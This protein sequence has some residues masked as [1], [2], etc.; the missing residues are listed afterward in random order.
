MRGARNKRSE[1]S[2]S[3]SRRD[4]EAAAVRP[5]PALQQTTG[6]ESEA[7]P[8][9]DAAASS[10]SLHEFQHNA[11]NQALVGLLSAGVIQRK[12]KDSASA[13]PSSAAAAPATTP[14]NGAPAL[15]VEDDAQEMKSGQMRK[16][17]FLGQ[18]RTAVSGTAEEALAGTMWSALGCPYIDRWLG[19]YGNQPSSYLERA[20][21]KYAPE[22]AGVRSARE[23]IPLVTQ[24]VR[25]GIEEWRSTGEVKDLPPEFAQGGMPGMSVSGLVGAGLSAVG[26]AAAG[27]VKG[28][29]RAISGAVSGIGSALSSVGSMLFKRREGSDAEA[30]EDPE[31]IR[32]QL[33]GGQ[34][35]DSRVQG[36]MKSAFGVDFAGVRVHTDGR[37]KELADGLDARAFTIGNDIAFG[38]QEYQPGTP[39][40]DALIA[41]ELA[42]VV[43]QGS[44]ENSRP[45]QKGGHSDHLEEDADLSAVNA[46]VSTWTDTK[47]SLAALGGNAIPRLRSGLRLQRCSKSKEEIEIERL[48]NLQFGFLEQKRKDEEQRLKKQ[49][50]EDAKKKGAPPPK[51]TPKV[52]LKDIVKKETEKHGIKGG[53]TAE[54]DN[55]D[56]AKWKKDAED[57]WNSLV[58][59]TKGTEL[60][61]IAK[62]AKHKFDPETALKEN[63]YAWQ[64]GDTLNFGMGWVANVKKDPK[65]GWANLAH[66]MGAH[67][68]YGKTYSSKIMDAALKNVSSKQRERIKGTD[69]D[70]YETYEYPETEIYSALW[71]RRYRVPLVGPAP[72]SGA[73]HPDDNIDIR[74]RTIKD[75]LQ[76]EVA[77]AVLKELK[78]RVDENDQ[79]LKRDKDFYVA[80]VKEIFN[81]D[82]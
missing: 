69:T 33:G 59:S 2:S 52:E 70:F 55:A 28:V 46:I 74:L 44:G 66:E 79:I 6:S 82:L 14:A 3:R 57:A 23:Y 8:L 38:P 65:N 62:H 37:A 40:G 68:K 56:Q 21:H 42:H 49:A 58:A 13:E 71:E 29:G 22:T 54:W 81:I 53:P 26:S 61:E 19:Y 4:G 15:I 5:S 9:T 76:P 16:S 75:V 51:E 63:Y 48:G 35:L 43:Q 1:L 47:E 34:A 24:R 72:E 64:S 10:D 45:M 77:L 67:F 32:G 11:G 12:E 25:R 17:E 80:K 18:L 73:I 27:A 50:E 31:A 20:L 30:A 60:E 78:R 41:H 7:A 36:R 39:V